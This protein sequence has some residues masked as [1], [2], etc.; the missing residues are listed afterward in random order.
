MILEKENERYKLIHLNFFSNLEA[1]A[2]FIEENFNASILGFAAWKEVVLAKY[3]KA[4]DFKSFVKKNKETSL[5]KSVIK[6]IFNTELHSMCKLGVRTE[7]D[8]YLS[9][10]SDSLSYALQN[11]MF[12][13][14]YLE[15][16][17][18]GEPNAETAEELYKY[19][20]KIIARL[21]P[22]SEQFIITQL[23]NN[24]EFFWNKIYKK[25]KYLVNVLNN[26][27]LPSEMSTRDDIWS[28]SC[29]ILNNALRSG[30]ITQPISCGVLF[31]YAIGIVRNKNKELL[32][33][34]SKNI[35]NIC[36]DIEK[37]IM[38]ENKSQN[39]IDLQYIDGMDDEFDFLAQILYNENHPQHKEFIAGLEDKVDILFA[40]Y[41]NKMTYEEIVKERRGNR[42]LNE[43]ELRTESAKLRKD[44]SRLKKVLKERF[45]ILQNKYKK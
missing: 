5:F 28:E 21:F 26:N 12:N 37:Y 42:I 17:V 2:V 15:Y 45:H 8:Y 23:V 20:Q 4:R 43:K 31:G 9:I 44:V 40:H 7:T 13:D 24:D 30:K 41:L 27:Y 1:E 29:C 18:S 22:L 39:Y 14:L 35:C 38:A 32:R 19:C 16:F 36:D 11:K 33:I 34:A 6:N 10:H 3:Y 25:M